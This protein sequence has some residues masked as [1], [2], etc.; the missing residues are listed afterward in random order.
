MK[1]IA[2]IMFLAGGLYGLQYLK[3]LDIGKEI[4]QTKE[5]IASKKINSI[6]KYE[7]TSIINIKPTNSE[8]KKNIGILKDLNEDKKAR[9]IGFFEYE[10]KA[11]ELGTEDFYKYKKTEK[12]EN[13]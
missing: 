5:T 11:R 8:D 7:S 3:E 13:Y 1:F 9:I 6:R 12:L 2:V 4:K 10:W